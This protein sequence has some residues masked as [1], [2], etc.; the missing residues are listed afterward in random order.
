MPNRTHTESMLIVT[1]HLLLLCVPEH[2]AERPEYEAQAIIA[3]L[4]Q[5]MGIQS[6]QGL[7]P[8]PAQMDPEQ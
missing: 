8:A 1:V 7:S 4:M 6:H 3:A 2:H 5:S